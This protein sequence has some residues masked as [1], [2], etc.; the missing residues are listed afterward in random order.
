MNRFDRAALAVAF[1]IAGLAGCGG[2]DEVVADPP[3]VSTNPATPGTAT[4]PQLSDTEAEAFVPARYFAKTGT[5]GT[6]GSALTPDPWT[7]PA[8][9]EVADFTPTFVVAADGSGTHTRLQDAFDA[10]PA[11]GAGVARTYILV[12][13]GTYRDVAC[14]NG[15]GPITL[16]GAGPD[17]AAVTFV[18]GTPA[19]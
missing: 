5:L 16:Y 9:G 7:P 4:R 18:A 3:A 6:D 1:S 19:A 10:A 17:A 13:P 2:D 14:A 15:K 8:V 11:A 12:K